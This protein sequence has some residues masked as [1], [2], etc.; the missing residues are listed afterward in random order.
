MRS[1]ITPS[2]YQQKK[3][4]KSMICKALNIRG[5]EEMLMQP[6]VEYLTFVKEIELA[7]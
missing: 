7:S 4:R 1:S 5:S 6:V 2:S 3:P